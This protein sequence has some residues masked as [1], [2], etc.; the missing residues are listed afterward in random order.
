MRT[1]HTRGTVASVGLI[2]LL[3]V[4]FLAGVA[5]ETWAQTPYVPE[6]RR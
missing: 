5:H 1:R 6:A 2:A 4:A 3:T